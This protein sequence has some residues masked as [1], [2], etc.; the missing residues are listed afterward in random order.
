LIFFTG[1]MCMLYGMGKLV[2]T[3]QQQ[4]FPAKQWRRG[5]WYPLA[6]APPSPVSVERTV[7]LSTHMTWLLSF[8]PRR[9]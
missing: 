7:A 2:H 5:G 1:G 3:D 8:E 9:G 4:L 6:N